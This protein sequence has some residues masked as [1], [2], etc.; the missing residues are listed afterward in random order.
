MNTKIQVILRSQ[1]T[2]ISGGLD[3]RRTWWLDVA[4][5]LERRG[6]QIIDLCV[7]IGVAT[8]DDLVIQGLRSQICI[9]SKIDGLRLEVAA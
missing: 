1:C 3:E 9:V 6:E 5:R 8:I 2:R 7:Q 4:A